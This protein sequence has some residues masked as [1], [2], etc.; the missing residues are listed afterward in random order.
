MS[1]PDNHAPRNHV[2]GQAH[3]S[4]IHQ[5]AA[6]DDLTVVS[7][8]LDGGVDVNIRDESLC[9]ALHYAVRNN[10]SAMVQLLLLRGADTSLRDNGTVDEPDGFTPVENAARLNMMA[11]MQE[12]IVHAVDIESSNAI[13]LAAR[14]DH[15]D[16]LHLLFDKISSNSGVSHR[17]AVADALR[18]SA[19]NHS[20]QMV[21]FML[22]KLDD[23]LETHTPNEYRQDALN[24]ALLAVFDYGDGMG[25]LPEYIRSQNWDHAIQILDIL[26]KAGA[27]INAHSDDP[28]RRTALHSAL[29]E[30]DPPSRLLVF[31]LERGADVNYRNSYG[32]SAF[33]ELLVHP[34]ATEEL[35]KVFTD[36]GAVVESPDVR[37]QTPLHGVCKPTIASWLIASGGDLS[38]VDDQG[39]IP[40]HKAI[41]NLELISLFVEAGS[42]I[43]K[44]NTLG[45]TP[46]MQSQFVSISK[47]LLDHGANIHAA[48]DQPLKGTTAIHQAARAC[49]SELLLFL[50]ANGADV[51]ARAARV[52]PSS[53]LSI[54][55]PVI[56]EGN[57]PLHLVVN[58]AAGAMG[59]DPLEVVTALL[60]HG[61]DIEAK[62]GTGKTPLLLA[63]TTEIYHKG[64]Y[65]PN[66]NVVELLLRRGANLYAIDD[67]AKNAF[68]LADDRHY[69]ISD[70]G[71]FE[72]KFVPPRSSHDYSMPGGRGRGRGAYGRGN[73]YS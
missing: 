14:E 2:A 36:A 38:A 51:H 11:A 71:N 9:T 49:N 4:S 47:L 13:H 59:G 23:E 34:K 66:K 41:H 22:Q 67:L 28:E 16:I 7:D 40:L 62:E 44:R 56:V 37:G 48:T 53:A 63:I 26:L 20:L 5:A 55:A 1:W 69:Q 15:M 61:A 35:V 33:F 70:T 64:S 39:E 12:L 50:L 18:E 19:K 17:Q 3:N 21:R 31:L 10:S 30:Q 52:V 6:N 57:T 8:L 73:F 60:D 45:W 32:R 58:S 72:R 46:F 68:Q 27:S 65:I 54:S 24:R 29:H 42:P 43:D 25:V